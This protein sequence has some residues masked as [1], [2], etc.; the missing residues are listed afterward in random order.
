MTSFYVLGFLNLKVFFGDKGFVKEW[1]FCFVSFVVIFRNY[2]T[3][4]SV[5]DQRLFELDFKQK[6]RYNLECH[7][8]LNE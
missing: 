3:L 4:A 7:I 2:V 5:I 8:N 1:L 6:V